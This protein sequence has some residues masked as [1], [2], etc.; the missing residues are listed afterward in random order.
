MYIEGPAGP[1]GLELR[2][3]SGFGSHQNGDVA[4][5][6]VCKKSP[7]GTLGLG[8]E[9]LGANLEASDGVRIMMKIRSGWK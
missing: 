2:S 6:R 7:G 5:A 8:R 1:L 4:E 9:A 3:E